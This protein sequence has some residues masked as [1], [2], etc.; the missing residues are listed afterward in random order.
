MML[1]SLLFIGGLGGAELMLILFFLGMPIILLLWALVDLLTSEFS[2]STNK[3]VWVIVI[4]FLPV[5]GAILYLL[6]GRKQK[7]RLSAR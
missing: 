6:I 2:D 5:L 7:T 3:L 4:L 1:N